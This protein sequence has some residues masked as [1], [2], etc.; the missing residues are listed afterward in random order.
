[1]VI[2]LTTILVPNTTPHELDRS[3]IRQRIMWKLRMRMQQHVR[4]FFH[5]FYSVAIHRDVMFVTPEGLNI[6]MHVTNN[7]LVTQCKCYNMTLISVESTRHI[8]MLELG[9]T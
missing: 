5:V 9:T 6:M 7:T 1:M 3:A 4:M 8:C 2:A